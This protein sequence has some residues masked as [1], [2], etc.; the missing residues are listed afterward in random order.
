MKKNKSTPETADALRRRAEERLK[1]VGA[2][3]PQGD[4]EM[5]K[6]LHELQV[7]QVELEMQNAEL[8]QA[9]TE[10]EAALER[11]T[12]LYDFAPIAYFT[13]D[14][15]SAIREVNLA[16]ADLLGIARSK[17]I[18]RHFG[19][20]VRDA[21]RPVFNA[22]LTKVRGSDAKEVCE[23]E[24]LKAD[25]SP[26]VAR[27]EAVAIGSGGVCRMVL[28][29]VTELR[30]TETSLR[31]SEQRY[32]E[33]FE[34]NPCAMLVYDMEC[35]RILAANDA[36]LALYGYTRQ[37][38]LGLTVRGLVPAEDVPAL[39][40]VTTGIN[41]ALNRSG[42]W[43]SRRKDGSLIDVEVMSHGLRFE[44]HKARLVLLT[45]VTRR[46]RAEQV[47]TCFRAALDYSTDAVFLLD[48]ETMR[49]VDINA[50]ASARLG[51]S[52]DELLRMG[53]Q[54]IVVD[55]DA[56]KVAGFDRNLLADAEKSAIVEA[57]YKCKDGSVFPA[58]VRLRAVET[59]GGPLLVAI[60]GDISQR[61]RAERMLRE[62]EQF[63]R[64]ILNTAIDGFLLVDR[65]GRF[66]DVNPAY[67]RMLGYTREE[68]LGLSLRDIEA[69]GTPEQ[70]SFHIG[71]IMA[72]GSDLFETRHLRKDG[73]MVEVEVSVNY[74]IGN[75]R[76]F[77][78]IRDITGRKQAEQERLR[79]AEQQRDT[80]VREVHHRIKNNLQGVIGL[81]D[82]YIGQHPEATD[83]L[84]NAIGKIRSVAVVFGMQGQ[85]DENDIR[86]CEMA[87]EICN[88]AEI[89]THGA[90]EPLIEVDL[91]RPIQVAKNTAVAIALIVNEL[92]T[93]ALKHSHKDERQEPVRV[94]IGTDGKSAILTIQNQCLMLPQGFDFDLGQ[95]MGT[96]L[97]LVRSMLPR[98]GA[99]L[100]LTF[101]QGIMT[102][103]LRLEPPVV[104]IPEF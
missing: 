64:N 24:L 10:A 54:D 37:E 44:E 87:A 59:E 35:L 74:L 102:A 85:R 29:D 47:A 42:L 97:D 104:T 95:G 31:E 45:D 41:P 92:V 48:I 27:I 75:N 63:N 39:L 66:L 11:Y 14:R 32:R 3:L 72:A 16:G 96:G 99:K 22:L 4:E 82:L 43:H 100:S 46:R 77:S 68:I 38:L 93:N 86:L 50:T 83:A 76:F 40:Q 20:F 52:R 94:R 9:R 90:V 2:L 56:Q 26:F 61:I 88:T 65:Q 6:L 36:A 49:F 8:L 98:E 70:A 53:P 91:A 60:V 89:L 5:H 34:D 58:E 67:C 51:Y 21:F 57:F 33:L 81:L 12:D 62:S 73:T 25:K 78:F 84:I 55:S 18:G 69:A 30:H 28:E 80:V 1:A 23:A 71:R 15:E 79:Q 13:L 103:E 17:L 101:D 7:Y 19:F